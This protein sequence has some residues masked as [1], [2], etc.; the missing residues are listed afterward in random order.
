MI[1]ITERRSFAI[2]AHSGLRFKRTCNAMLRIELSPALNH[3]YQS[4]TASPEDFRMVTYQS[5]RCEL[6]AAH[7]YRRSVKKIMGLV[8][9]NDTVDFDSKSILEKNLLFR[10]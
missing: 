9:Q 4:S 8:T 5:I 6:E 1:Q 3:H 10:S 7:H 2:T